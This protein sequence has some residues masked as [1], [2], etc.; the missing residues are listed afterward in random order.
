MTS[1]NL[2]TDLHTPAEA[3]TMPPYF[4]HGKGNKDV[5]VR[6]GSALQYFLR[7]PDHTFNSVPNE[8]P[9]SEGRMRRSKVRDMDKSR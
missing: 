5:F 3:F 8:T 4:K 2:S 7:M 1:I 6:N 9:Q